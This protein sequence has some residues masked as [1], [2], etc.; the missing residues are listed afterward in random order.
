M[1]PTG[2]SASERKYKYL[3]ELNRNLSHPNYFHPVFMY[4]SSTHAGFGEKPLG[5]L[6]HKAGKKFMKNEKISGPT[7][8]ES[9][10]ALPH[11]DSIEE[12]SSGSGKKW[13]TAAL[14]AALL[15]AVLILVMIFADS[16]VVAKTKNIAIVVC[17]F[18]AILLLGSFFILIFQLS[19]L[20]N[21]LKIEIKP[22]LESTRDT[23]NNVKGTVSF[24]SDKI[25]EPAI[26]VGAKVA[27]AKKITSFL[28]RRK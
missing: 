10:V 18:A 22:V 27:G 15:I 2:I 9:Y 7:G 4:N 6:N 24:M 26:S 1:K 23:V 19:A 8:K 13:L 20:T 14:I 16:E 11:E 28:F 17:S 21:L 5:S 25:V 12:E 3:S